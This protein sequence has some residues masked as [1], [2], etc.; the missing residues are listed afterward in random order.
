MSEWFRNARQSV[1]FKIAR[2]VIL[3]ALA[4]AGLGAYIA[5]PTWPRKGT[6]KPPQVSQE[7][8]RAH[9]LTLSKRFAP[10]S[11]NDRVNLS[12]CAAYIAG[13]FRKTRGRVEMQEYEFQ[14]MA[15]RNV[16]V[17][18]GPEDAPCIVVGANFDAYGASPGADNNASGVAGLI[19]L[20]RLLDQNP[21]PAVRIDL[22]AFALSEP[23]YFRTEEMGSR[24]YVRE[25][26]DH[27][28]DVRGMV[29]LKCIGFFSREK[30]IQKFPLAPLGLFYPDTGNFIEVVGSPGDRRLIR[31]VKASMK[32]AADLPVYSMCLPKSFPGVAFAD[33]VSFWE[34]GW[35]AVMVTDTA[36]Y[37]N[38]A[39]HAA[40]D[41]SPRLDYNRMAQVV[42]G[43]YEAL[44]HLAANP[45]KASKKQQEPGK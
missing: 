45:P 42:E 11:G 25:L 19:E 18:F 8:L 13:Q 14:N 7:R 40:M 32:G 27:K 15:Y 6:G 31:S 34:Q 17:S 9:V 36:L 35:P 28:V 5:Q 20:S 23:P 21:A 41:I 3:L 4:F 44:A 12:R 39:N 24:H 33:H 16:V 30:G 43:V 10:R 38:E 37:R 22:A 1:A 2:S 26:L 29:C